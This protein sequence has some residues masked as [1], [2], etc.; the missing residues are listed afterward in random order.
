MSRMFALVPAAGTGSR[1][2]EGTPKQYRIL[3][4]RPMVHH[5]LRTLAAA[6]AIERVFLVLAPGDA[7]GRAEDWA[8]LSPKIVPLYCGGA[9]RAET[10]VNGLREAPGLGD[11][12]W[13][14]V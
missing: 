10:V 6:R 9:T 13:V 5:A 8:S 11:E 12:D 7:E 2:G 3:A 14:L 1:L 4:G